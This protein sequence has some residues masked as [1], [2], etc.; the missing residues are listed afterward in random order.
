MQVFYR[1]L[2]GLFQLCDAK[3]SALFHYVSSSTAIMIAR[4]HIHSSKVA[5]VRGHCEGS[6][7]AAD[8]PRHVPACII[9]VVW[10]MVLK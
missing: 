1:P 6:H 7:S 2:G 9:H 5:S 10:E 8:S 3:E 4:V